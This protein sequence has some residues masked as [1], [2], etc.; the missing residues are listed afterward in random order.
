MTDATAKIEALQV[1]KASA[2]SV[3]D[4]VSHITELASAHNDNTSQLQRLQEASATSEAALATQ[5]GRIESIEAAT[6]ALEEAIVKKLEKDDMD[7]IQEALAEVDTRLG[8][9][10]DSAKLAEAEQGI[11]EL[12]AAADE[13]VRRLNRSED[14]IA[15]AQGELKQH[16]EGLEALSGRVEGLQS[17]REATEA[18]VC[19]AELRVSGLEAGVGYSKSQVEGMAASL[20]E[21]RDELANKS[22]TAEVERVRTDVREVEERMKGLAAAADVARLQEALGAVTGEVG[23]RLEA[24]EG[25]AA[26]GAG[27]LEAELQTLREAQAALQAEAEKR[28]GGLEE[29]CRAL[30][31]DVGTAGQANSARVQHLATCDAL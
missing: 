26:E 9:L 25:A 22:D 3:N 1:A 21:L 20:A 10:A 29:Q 4:A 7:R 24:V 28:M 31:G 16:A 8:G 14:A 11:V 5:E 2:A 27:R 30:E 13:A 23:G 19:A 18:Q 17:A 12:R 15:K 6:R